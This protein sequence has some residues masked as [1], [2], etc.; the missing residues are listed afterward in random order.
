VA[1]NNC[2]EGKQT[3]PVD[4]AN[5]TIPE[6][7]T[8]PIPALI[9]CHG[10][11]INGCDYANYYSF[12]SWDLPFFDLVHTTHYTDCY[13]PVRLKNHSFFMSVVCKEKDERLYSACRD[14]YTIDNRD[15]VLSFSDGQV[16]VAY[17]GPFM[18]EDG[19]PMIP[20]H[21]SYVQAI[22]SYIRYKIAYR[23]YDME[24]DRGMMNVRSERLSRA[25]ADW[26][27]YCRQALNLGI[28]GG[29]GADLLKDI[30]DIGNYILPPKTRYETFFGNL[31]IPQDRLNVLGA[32][33]TRR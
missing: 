29:G 15:L 10:H 28:L 6:P 3:C 25:E 26:H 12:V 32:E 23:E 30:Q 33:N 31:T 7:T 4:L 20:D 17:R 22:L 18:D 13:T 16:V 2:Y 27:F 8:Q 21:E 14:E 5:T 1:R 9:D 19:Y 11:L 24:T